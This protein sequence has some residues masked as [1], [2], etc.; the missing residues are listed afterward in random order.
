MRKLPETEER[1]TERIRILL[2]ACTELEIVPVPTSQNGNTYNSQGI[3]Y[4]I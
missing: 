3:E 2:D 4:S 1:V